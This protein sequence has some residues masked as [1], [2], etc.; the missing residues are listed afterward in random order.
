MR[1]H[2]E[3]TD[4][5]LGNNTTNLI[6]QHSE[7]PGPEPYLLHRNM[8]TDFHS[9]YVQVFELASQLQWEIIAESFPIVNR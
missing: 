3:P 7:Y 1:V 2:I 5:G 4:H 6:F 9:E 8:G